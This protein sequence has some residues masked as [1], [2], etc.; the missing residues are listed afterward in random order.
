MTGLSVNIGANISGLSAG[1]AQAGSQLSTFVSGAN[2]RLQSLGDSF[3]SVGQKISIGLSIPLGLLSKQLLENG[4]GL[5]SLKMGLK[6]IEEQ[7]YG[8]GKSAEYAA[9]RYAEYVEIAKLPGIGLKEA[10][11][12]SIGLRSVGFSADEAKRQILVFGNTLA[13]VGKGKNELSGVALQIQQ[14]AGKSQGFGADLRVIK[15]YAPQVGGALLK[16]F[17]TVDT[18]SIAKTGVTGKQVIE[19]I[20]TELEKLPKA[21]AGLKT[22]MENVSDSIF[23]TTGRIGLALNKALG[24]TS[25]FDKIGNGLK[26]L[27]DS[28]ENLSP[29]VQK[30]IGIVGGVLIIAPPILIAIGAITAAIGGLLSPV[31][32]IGVGI[33]ALTAIVASNWDAIT[34]YLKET[35]VWDGL[36]SMVTNTWDM[37][38]SIFKLAA[39]VV[40]GIF[41]FFGEVLEKDTFGIF[42]TISSIIGSVFQ[43]IGGLTKTIAGIMSGDWKK[44]GDGLINITA[45]FFEFIMTITEGFMLAFIGIF[46]KPFEW[47]GMS[48]VVKTFEDGSSALKT[49]FAGFRTELNKLGNDV[50]EK[51]KEI[52]K[53]L[54]NINSAF[55]KLVVD[56]LAS[57]NLGNVLSSAYLFKNEAKIEGGKGGDKPATATPVDEAALKK[58]Q[59]AREEYFKNTQKLLGEALKIENSLIADKYARELAQEKQAYNEKVKLA[60]DEKASK[61]SKHRILE[62]LEREHQTNISK[63]ITEEMKGRTATRA[64]G[65]MESKGGKFDSKMMGQLNVAFNL[66]STALNRPMDAIAA[67]E[68]RF[69]TIIDGFQKQSNR[70]R[71]MWESLGKN[72]RPS[73]ELLKEVMMDSQQTLAQTTLN[74]GKILENGAKSLAVGFGKTMGAM[75]AGKAGMKDVGTML[76]EGF[77]DIL[78]Q[79]GTQLISSAA[80]FALGAAALITPLTP[81]GAAGALAAGIGLVALGSALSSS[82]SGGSASSSGG[83]G[84]GGGYSQNYSSG[85]NMNNGNFNG[86]SGQ[87]LSLDINV[88]GELTMRRNELVSSIRQTS[89]YQTRTYGG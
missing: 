71:L 54:T 36:V 11:G 38:S 24:L 10:I 51:S 61:E 64:D 67:A 88:G 21:G 31:I 59:K 72:T 76:L 26:S 8:V 82:A 37:I 63:I 16:A 18:E 22:A 65:G 68:I 77:G 53:N 2:S 50:E 49:Q 7:Q 29:E 5:E 89:K 81:A 6:S 41:S 25:I 73:A 62:A 23:I 35:G 32:L 85:S 30:L 1:I 9:K 78:T 28:F 48:A 57:S 83:S 33:I 70:L 46:K 75:M 40:I 58:A 56:N 86:G 12:M 34:G 4:G 47:I 74:M 87:R 80:L 27:A 84:G 17:G 20:T 44:M 55:G 45:G 43:I 14:L 69:K 39:G 19:R 42:T 60:N 3:S 52:T 66:A 79:L 13:L 15:E